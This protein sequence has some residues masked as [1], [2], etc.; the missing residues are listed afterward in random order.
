MTRRLSV[1]KIVLLLCSSMTVMAGA[2][3]APAL[4]VMSQHFIEEGGTETT[5]KLVLTLPG[6]FIAL[7]A[8]ISG[9]L[10]DRIGRKKILIAGLLLYGFSGMAGLVIND[11]GTLLVSRAILGLA[12]A[13]IM[14]GA[15]TLVADYFEGDERKAFISL[16]G[17][18]MALGGVVYIN[19]GGFLA[20]ISWRGP[21]AMY[22]FAW[23]ILPLAIWLLEE[24]FK[25]QPN[26]SSEFFSPKDFG[27]MNSSIAF[28]YILGFLGMAFF[29]LIPTQIPFYVINQF[30]ANNSMI[31]VAVSVSTFM[32]AL[33]SLNYRFI[34]NL[35]G[36]RA[37]YTIT[38]GMMALGYW[39]ISQSDSLL[40][41]FIG[42]GVAGLGSGLLMPNG[43]L[44][45][46]QI[47]P[48]Q[49][50]GKVLGL[51]TSSIFM[52]QFFSP[53]LIDLLLKFPF[54]HNLFLVAAM[55]LGLGTVWLGF[56][57]QRESDR[58][59]L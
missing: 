12:V 45:L 28:V 29:Y 58:A 54:S 35:F 37:I 1:V 20:D 48:E 59:T 13:G 15:S 31:G 11:L 42:L 50:R 30:Q 4:P 27:F 10:A 24:V 39:I 17:T 40:M 9:F 41:V 25:P 55:L 22:G 51:F 16:Q 2:I 52:G 36:F 46:M 23:L 7:M 47:A 53:I 44:W 38:A 3:I 26:A 49:S 32:G 19:L 21:F 57:A 6:L 18:F 56:L 33:A 8:P 43:S 34:A 5:T 14:S